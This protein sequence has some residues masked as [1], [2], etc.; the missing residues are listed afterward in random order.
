MGP[1]NA[2]LELGGPRVGDPRVGTP[3]VGTPR[4]GTPRV[5][6]PRVGTPRVGDPRV[7]TPRVG[8]LFLETPGNAEL[9]LG[10]QAS[11][12]AAEKKPTSIAAFSGESEPW[13]AL[14]SMDSP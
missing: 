2:E 12:E 11:S 1:R 10:L 5:G 3:R 4:V 7:G 14:R 6:T 8:T 9:Q 13:M